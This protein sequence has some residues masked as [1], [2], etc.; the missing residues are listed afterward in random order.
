MNKL[1]NTA[2]NAVVIGVNVM[3]SLQSLGVQLHIATEKMSYRAGDL[4]SGKIWINSVVPIPMQSISLK[5]SGWE[6][7]RVIKREYIYDDVDDQKKFHNADIIHHQ[8]GNRMNHDTHVQHNAD[9][10]ST[11][12]GRWV[13]IPHSQQNQIIN[14]DVIIANYTQM[15][16]PGSY[17]FPFEFVLPDSLSGCFMESGQKFEASIEYKLT[18]I[19]R[20][21]GNGGHSL[22]HS[23]PF[24]VEEKLKHM[25]TEQMVTNVKDITFCW[26]INKGTCTISA[27]AEKNA[28]FPG[29]IQNTICDIQ[30]DSK[31]EIKNVQLSIKRDFSVYASGH[32]EKCSKQVVC[33]KHN[34]LPSG[35]K[36][37]KEF[38]IPIPMDL[39]PTTNGSLIKS[40]YRLKVKLI[41]KGASNV[42]V[43]MPLT[44][45]PASQKQEMFQPPPN[46]NIDTN[47]M[48]IA[49]TYIVQPSAPPMPSQFE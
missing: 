5:I 13:D 18:A 49:D 36:D 27:V 4:V 31:C 39:K 24:Y 14:M 30:N 11:Q 21:F 26:F 15:L 45:Y 32:Y 9:F 48:N 35:Y 38:S 25:I 7:T 2:V 41:M 6:T 1:I 22:S 12:T 16:N 23:Q 44:V 8:N 28:V 33:V 10:H 42:D 20:Q 43:A 46:W 37:T 3:R 19:C 47:Q 40:N 17:C 34:G 29:D